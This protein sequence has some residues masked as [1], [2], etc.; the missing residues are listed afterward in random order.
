MTRS[1]EINASVADGFYRLE[2]EGEA[3]FVDVKDGR[4]HFR[5]RNFS[6]PVAEC[7]A[8]GD[9]F[10][11]PARYQPMVRTGRNANGFSRDGGHV[12]HAVPLLDGETK[13]NDGSARKAL[14][15]AQPQGIA[16]WGAPIINRVSCPRCLRKVFP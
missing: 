1:E 14:C 6:L 8:D 4:A 7:L 11:A 10:K 5:G 13:L 9:V 3:Y 16:F 12:V 15:G 2:T